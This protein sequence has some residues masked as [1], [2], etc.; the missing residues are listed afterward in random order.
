MPF[1]DNP[2]DPHVRAWMGQ[3]NAWLVI[4]VIVALITAICYVAQDRRPLPEPAEP[5]PLE[6]PLPFH[7]GPLHEE[8]DSLTQPKP[9]STA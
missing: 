3:M 1:L 6:E 4:M 2:D 7:H 9:A 8:P 5:S